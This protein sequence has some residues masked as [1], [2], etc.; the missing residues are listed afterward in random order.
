MI[1]DFAEIETHNG[2]FGIPVM[3]WYNSM[4]Y[5][6]LSSG[7]PE[8]I[9]ESAF[10]YD[11]KN[12]FAVYQLRDSQDDEHTTP[13]RYQPYSELSQ[14]G[15]FVDR[16][17]YNL[18]YTGV[19]LPD[20]TPEGLF[21][22]FNM[23]KP[24]GFLGRSMGI[25]DVLSLQENGKITSYYV[26]S[27][28][29]TE[30]LSFI[31]V[32][33]QNMTRRTESEHF[34]QEAEAPPQQIHSM[35]VSTQSTPPDSSQAQEPPKEVTAP[36]DSPEILETPE[37][38]SELPP[39]ADSANNGDALLNNIM[40]TAKDFTDIEVYPQSLN[41]AKDYGYDEVYK[42]NLMI[43]QQC[44]ADIDSAIE[45]SKVTGVEGEYRLT[46]A[47]IKV[48]AKYGRNRIAWVLSMAVKIAASDVFSEEN[49][50]WSDETLEVIGFPEEPPTFFIKTFPVL[51]NVFILRFREAQKQKLGYRERIEQA[52]KRVQAQVA[53]T[54]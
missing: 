8:A 26:D 39:P 20:D 19:L 11:G 23:N 38:L 27:G 14:L 25:S 54:P 22:R 9:Q 49:M 31:G 12:A 4:E 43:N 2:I 10:I 29:Y 51:L 13:Y 17:N 45:N 21:M 41:E 36:P 24:Q 33:N 37:T 48:V 1:L 15:L 44:A 18:V 28:K 53:Q 7:N 34:E 40:S 3:E 30:L 35:E 50:A 32:E 52:T 5:I 42:F 47:V 16:S 6:A 46:E